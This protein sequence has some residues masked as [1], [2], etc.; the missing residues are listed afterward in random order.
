MG[1]ASIKQFLENYNP[2]MQTVDDLVEY[3][4]RLLPP[5]DAQRIRDVSR[6]LELAHARHAHGPGGSA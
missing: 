1:Y 5:A 2:P 3:Q 4:I 6:A